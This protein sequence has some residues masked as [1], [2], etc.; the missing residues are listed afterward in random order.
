MLEIFIDKESDH[1]E[2]GPHDHRSSSWRGM[3]L[4]DPPITMCIL[5][6][7][8]D[9]SFGGSGDSFAVRVGIRDQGG[10]T[11]GLLYDTVLAGMSSSAWGEVAPGSARVLLLLTPSLS[12]KV[13]LNALRDRTRG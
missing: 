8:N 3:H 12:N 4:T 9:R 6:V 7:R 10:L 2:S 5:H 13:W 11:L 1:N